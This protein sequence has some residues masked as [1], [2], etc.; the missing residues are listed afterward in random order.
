M[1]AKFAHW[2]PRVLATITVFG[3][4]AQVGVS[5]SAPGMADDP[6]IAGALRQVSAEKIQANIEKLVG[7]GTRLGGGCTSGHGV[8]GLSRGSP[9]SFVATGTFMLVAGLVVFC[10]RHVFVGATP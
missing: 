9:R 1:R 3:A 5:Q 4:M 6:Q 10:T 8:C 7:F 2:A